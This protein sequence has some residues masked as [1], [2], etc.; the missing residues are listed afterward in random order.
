MCGTHDDNC[1]G[2]ARIAI[3]EARLRAAEA[4]AE[5]YERDWYDAKSKFGDAMAAMRAKLRAAEDALRVAERTLSDLVPD[6]SPTL[7]AIR[8]A[9]VGR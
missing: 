8:A 3:L 1:P 9:L 7:A 6:R 4:K 5:T 2:N